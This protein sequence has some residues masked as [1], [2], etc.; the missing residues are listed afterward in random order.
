MT[1]PYVCHIWFAIYHQ[2]TPIMLASIYHTYGS[3]G[4][5]KPHIYVVFS[6]INQPFLG[7]PHV[8]TPPSCNISSRASREA[9]DLEIPPMHPHV[10]VIRDALSSAKAPGGKPNEEERFNFSGG[11]HIYG[12]TW[13]VYNEKSHWNIWNG[14]IVLIFHPINQFCRV[15]R[16]GFIDDSPIYGGF[17]RW[18]YP[19]NGWFI[20]EN[21][22]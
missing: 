2:Y 22:I 19:K 16:I 4:Y 10:L 8:W 9:K 5:I 12:W 18:W 1:D 14:F 17:H 13:M 11:F 3:Y 6:H 20:L 21:P 15:F 7:Y